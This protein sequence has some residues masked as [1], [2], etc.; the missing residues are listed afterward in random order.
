M[1]KK[2][3]PLEE[4]MNA[5]RNEPENVLPRSACGRVGCVTIYKTDDCHL[6]EAVDNYMKD[7]VKSEGFSETII[8]TVD[9]SALSEEPNFDNVH[10]VPAVRVCETIMIGLPDDEKMRFSLRTAN[11]KKCFLEDVT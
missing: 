9:K 8:N 4:K 11:N 2:I 1:Q 5:S 6:C 3:E 10:S 7:L